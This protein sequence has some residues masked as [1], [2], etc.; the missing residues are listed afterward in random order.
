MAWFSTKKTN[1][2]FIN[3]IELL[4]IKSLK[5]CIEQSDSKTVIIFKHSTRCSISSMAKSKLERN[6]NYKA[7]EIT[8]YYLDLIANRAISN[9]IEKLLGVRHQSPQLIV[10]KNKRVVLHLSHNAINAK[11]LK[12]YI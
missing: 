2:E 6:W 5:E 12:E 7:D 1:N 11:I 4:D 10:L 9:E 3:W 8:P